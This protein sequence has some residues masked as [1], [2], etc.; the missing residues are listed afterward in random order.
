MRRERES[1][2]LPRKLDGYRVKI[3]LDPSKEPSE[4]Q[5]VMEGVLE[6]RFLRDLITNAKWMLQPTRTNPFSS[7]SWNY[8]IALLELMESA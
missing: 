8:L 7:I 3:K 5:K 4:V 2:L 1:S 6:Q